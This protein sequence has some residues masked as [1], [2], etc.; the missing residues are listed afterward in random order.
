MVEETNKN[1]VREGKAKTTK[2]ELLKWF[3]TSILLLITR[4]EFGDHAA[5]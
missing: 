1:L 5:L 4:F 3:G 2:G